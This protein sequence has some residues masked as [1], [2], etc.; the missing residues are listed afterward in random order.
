MRIGVFGGSFN[1]VHKGHLRVAKSAIQGLMLDKLI[2]MPAAQNPLRKGEKYNVSFDGPTRLM[3]ARVAFNGWPKVEV[4]AREINR[5]G[6]SY[7]IDTVRSLKDEYP[8]ADFFFII[9]ED[10]LNDLEKWKDIDELRRLV[11]F[12]TFPRTEESS[13]EVRSRIEKGGEIESLVGETVALFI[14]HRVRE[15]PD[16]RVASVVRKGLV[17]K[18][19]FCP[20]RLPKKPEFFCPCDEFRGQLADPA[21][22]GLCHCRLYDKP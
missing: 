17:R 20:C 1:P 4:D 10:S 3:L 9:G 14:K 16:D 21:F 15:N 6:V 18:E 22:R 11:T 12:S 13:T 5:G 19:G 2:I 7:A 8:S